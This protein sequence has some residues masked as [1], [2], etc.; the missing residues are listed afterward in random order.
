MPSPSLAIGTAS[1]GQVKILS[2][3]LIPISIGAMVMEISPASA[4]AISDWPVIL[5]VNTVK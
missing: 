3:A 2:A 1:K 5:P 4:Y